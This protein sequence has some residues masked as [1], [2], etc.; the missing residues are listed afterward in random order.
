MHQN[1]S[2]KSCRAV[3]PPIRK[4]GSEIWISF[5]PELETDDTHR[6]FALNPP[7]GAVV[8][9]T[10]WR[11][12]PALSDELRAEIEHLKATDQD[13]YEHVYEDMCRQAVTGGL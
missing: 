4:P 3:I 2:K 13:E 10:S 9:K 11:D 5:K 6:R 7:P 8:V 12:N 1:V